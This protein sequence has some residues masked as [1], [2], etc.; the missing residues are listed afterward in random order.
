MGHHASA[1]MGRCF[2][3]FSSTGVIPRPHRLNRCETNRRFGRVSERLPE[4]HWHPL[5][6]RGGTRTCDSSGVAGVEYGR[7]WS[8]ITI[9]RSVCSFALLSQG[10][11]IPV[12]YSS[13]CSRVHGCLLVH[14]IQLWILSNALTTQDIIP[15]VGQS[16][17]KKNYV[18]LPTPYTL[19]KFIMHTIA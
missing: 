8:N 16:S 3:S 13:S 14:V 18:F 10:K 15:S 11:K 7:R 2:V 4:A 6:T 9:R 19:T 1:R 17:K 5:N 12:V